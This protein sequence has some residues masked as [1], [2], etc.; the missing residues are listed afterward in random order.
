MP[1]PKILALAG[2]LRKGSFNK[3]MVRIAADAAR[4]AGAEVT[5][6]ELNDFPMPV[7]DGDIEAKGFPETVV[8]LNKIFREHHALL[9][10]SPE[11]N[12]SISGAFKNTI[13]WISRP[14]PG[15]PHVP[16][17]A[18]FDGKVAAIM[19]ASMGELG[20]LRGLV[21]L[22]S[23]LGNIKVIVLPEQVT[24]SKAQ[25]AFDQAGNLKE[26]RKLEQIR[27]LAIRLVHVASKLHG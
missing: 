24:I 13:D 11:Y 16:N 21:A 22:R 15:P 27:A 1:T 6:L 14:E 9:L 20:G 25:E 10:A 23:M 19:S 2:S 5:L 8:R 17:V 3:M 18:A 7:Y 26:P 12:S 4:A